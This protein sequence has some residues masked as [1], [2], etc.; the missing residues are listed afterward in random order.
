MK[1]ALVEVI[2]FGHPK[3]TEVTMLS[4][5]CWF[6]KSYQ[7]ILCNNPAC[8]CPCHHGDSDHHYFKGAVR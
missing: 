6:G 3:D 4:W 2:A 5:E 7:A 8:E 1:R